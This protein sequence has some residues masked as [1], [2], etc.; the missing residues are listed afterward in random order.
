MNMGGEYYY[1]EANNQINPREKREYLAS[2]TPEQRKE[3]DKYYNKIRQRKFLLNNENRE[4]T[5]KIRLEHIREL[6]TSPETSEEMK[7]QNIKDVKNF[8]LRQKAK[9]Q[10]I[11]NKINATNK[12]NEAIKAKKAREELKE[13]KELKRKEEIK[14]DIGDILNSIID[15]IPKKAQQKRNKEAVARHRD[16]KIKG[17]EVKTYNTRSKTKATK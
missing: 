9:Q 8:R 17:E 3:Y 4:R 12:I 15:T 11:L 5:N 6:R 14:G 7:Q 10:E 13:L 1:N 2:L 16:K